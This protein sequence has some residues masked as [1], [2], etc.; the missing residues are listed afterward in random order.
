MLTQIVI[1]QACLA[2]HLNQVDSDC[3]SLISTNH[4]I[5]YQVFHMKYPSAWTLFGLK[6]PDRSGCLGT[7]LV[8]VE[9]QQHF[10]SREG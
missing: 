7:D 10:E 5:F 1:Y 6:P 8:V 4:L 2:K 3:I 9:I